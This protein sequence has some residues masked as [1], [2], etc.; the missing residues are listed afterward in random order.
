MDLWK[1][2]NQKWF[3][4]APE[5][6]APSSNMAKNPA[7]NKFKLSGFEVERWGGERGRRTTSSGLGYDSGE[8]GSG[9]EKGGG[10]TGFKGAAHRGGARHP[11]W[12][13]RMRGGAKVAGATLLPSS[14][15]YDS[16]SATVAL[17]R[18]H[19]GWGRHVG[20]RHQPLWRQKGPFSVYVFL[21]VYL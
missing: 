16:P 7:K 20:G 13:R 17:S 8:N 4:L 11:C 21:G 5:W 19:D 18:R 1:N 14:H 9:E 3:F 10:A 15:R 2:L 6:L 12:R